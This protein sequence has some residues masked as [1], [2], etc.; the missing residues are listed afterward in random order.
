MRFE[1]EEHDHEELISL[2]ALGT[3]VLVFGEMVEEWI[4]FS[5]NRR[6]LRWCDSILD[7][8]LIKSA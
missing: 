1:E 5:N 2:T 8:W 4:V 6:Y 3:G 7:D